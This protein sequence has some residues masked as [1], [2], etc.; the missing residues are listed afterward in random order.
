MLRDE[1]GIFKKYFLV[2]D[3]D[4]LFVVA[5]VFV[6]AV[7]VLLPGLFFFQ[8]VFTFVCLCFLFIFKHILLLKNKLN[9]GKAER[10]SPLVFQTMFNFNKPFWNHCITTH[11]ERLTFIP[12]E[13]FVAG[14]LV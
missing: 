6:F 11:F 5:A 14:L 3:D 4:V 9:T 1:Y 2:V 10:E 7:V 8:F 13:I 12:N